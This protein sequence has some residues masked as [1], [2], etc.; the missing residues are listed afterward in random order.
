MTLQY[1]WLPD[2]SISFISLSPN[3][4]PP[5]HGNIMLTVTGCQVSAKKC[6]KKSNIEAFLFSVKIASDIL[7]EI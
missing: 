6:R 4:N 2:Y 1:S 7:V 3:P 5:R